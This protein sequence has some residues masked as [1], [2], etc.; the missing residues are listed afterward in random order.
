MQ[1]FQFRSHKFKFYW[2]SPILLLTGTALLL[3]LGFWQLHRAQQKE[4]LMA[5]YD[6]A[7]Q[8]AA[9][10]FNS[11]QNESSWT[12]VY[13]KGEYVP[14]KTILLSQQFKNHQRGYE[15]FTLLMPSQSP[16][17]SLSHPTGLWVNRGFW[18]PPPGDNIVDLKNLPPLPKGEVLIQGY[19]LD[20][21]Q[22]FVL[23]K[24]PLQPT[25]PQT[26]DQVDLKALT[27]LLQQPFY[28][29]S[30]VL[31]GNSPGVLTPAEPP[32]IML[33]PSRHRA[34][35][36]QWFVLALLFVG[37]LIAAHRQTK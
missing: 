3:G 1:I 17:P 30:L 7:V 27:R 18:S 29:K 9:K 21:P 16:D 24:L 10:S 31:Q 13:L 8:Q 23:K 14:E 35:A 33:T 11:Q 2:F 26:V 15:M 22:P 20:P 28:P 5:H 37:I 12:P 32:R 34:Y 25:F 6:T 4:Q 36:A 19:L